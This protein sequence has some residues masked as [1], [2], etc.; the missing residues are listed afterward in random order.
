MVGFPP[1]VSLIERDISK[2]FLDT[3][4]EIM[5][6]VPFLSVCAGR[7]SLSGFRTER[8]HVENIVFFWTVGLED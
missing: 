1:Y 5:T 3:E 6:S 7:K 4:K 8:S 2:L